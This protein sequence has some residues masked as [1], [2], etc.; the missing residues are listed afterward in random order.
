[1]TTRLR[2]FDPSV[3]YDG[4]S[5]YRFIV[6]YIIKIL[7]FKTSVPWPSSLKVFLL[8]LFGATVG[9]RVVLKPNINF[10]FP[11]NLS[12]GSDVWIG[13]DVFVL[14]FS[15][16]TI[17]SNVCIS[18]RSFLCTGNHNFRDQAFSYRNAPITIS[19]GCWIGASSFIGPG[20]SIGTESVVSAGTILTQSIGHNLII[21]PASNLIV[22]KRWI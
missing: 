18:Q 20:V 8:R 5:K 6:W 19:S 1:M 11:W 15:P 14:N 17:S 7:F 10:H 9:K 16:V 4:H 2:L 12:I 21:K 13:E 3:N 22:G